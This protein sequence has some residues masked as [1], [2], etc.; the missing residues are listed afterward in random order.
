M[1]QNSS[2]S[3]MSEYKLSWVR[4]ICVVF[5]L[6]QQN[7]E[8]DL[9]TAADFQKPVQ[10]LVFLSLW[11]LTPEFNDED[12]ER[13]YRPQ[14]V[15][16]LGLKCYQSYVSF[17]A[18]WSPECGCFRSAT[19][20]SDSALIGCTTISCTRHTAIQ[21][22]NQQKRFSPFFTPFHH[23]CHIRATLVA[24]TAQ[25]PMRFPFDVSRLCR[26]NQQLCINRPSCWDAYCILY[27]GKSRMSQHLML[28]GRD[29]KVWYPSPKNGSTTHRPHFQALHPWSLTCFTWK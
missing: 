8:Q 26:I 18:S 11:Q 28:L 1:H 17:L 24:G 29:P 16:Y 7:N 13:K 25:I 15:R 19:K 10:P 6:T 12:N 14:M 9:E 21:K 4:M 2:C 5:H 3:T 23:I 22:T 20:S 27:H